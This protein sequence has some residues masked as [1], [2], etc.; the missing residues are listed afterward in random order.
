MII[1]HSSIHIAHTIPRNYIFQ[2]LFLSREEI[3]S[4]NNLEEFWFN[5]LDRYIVKVNSQAMKMFTTFA[6]MKTKGTKN[7]N[8]TN[9]NWVYFLCRRFSFLWLLNWWLLQKF[10][11]KRSLC[12]PGY[13][14]VKI[15]HDLTVFFMCK[16]TF[17]FY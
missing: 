8:S 17:K 1:F 11:K 16:Y 5:R 7:K 12:H 14:Q 6:S 10:H 9:L 15:G 3:A 2:S 4:S 13:K